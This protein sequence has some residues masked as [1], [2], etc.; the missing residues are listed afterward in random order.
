[1]KNDTHS[2]N[3]FFENSKMINGQIELNTDI[4]NNKIVHDLT[5]YSIEDI[6]Y[7]L[8]D[9]CQF[10]AESLQPNRLADFWI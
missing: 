10:I 6:K 8:F 9:L 2:F 1:M 7:C 5:T 4:W 3:K